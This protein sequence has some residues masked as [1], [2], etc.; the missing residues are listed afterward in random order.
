MHNFDI[1]DYFSMFMV[2][3]IVGDLG[4]LCNPG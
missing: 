4:Q 2:N 3:F 1:M